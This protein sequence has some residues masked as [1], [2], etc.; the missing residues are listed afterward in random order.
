MVGQPNS[1][2]SDPVE[3]LVTDPEVL[4]AYEPVA[5]ATFHREIEVVVLERR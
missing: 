5:E 1:R 3:D 4:A 2:G